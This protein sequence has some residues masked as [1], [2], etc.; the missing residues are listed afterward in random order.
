LVLIASR[1]AYSRI[2]KFIPAV[3]VENKAIT[4]SMWRSFEII[5]PNNE[6]RI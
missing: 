2:N 1:I 6:S 3:E 5:S 4:S